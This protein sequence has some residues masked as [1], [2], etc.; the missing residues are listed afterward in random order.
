MRAGASARVLKPSLL[1]LLILALSG[2]LLWRAVARVPDGAFALAGPRV[3]Q[4]GLHVV[5]PWISIAVYPSSPVQ[6][7]STTERVTR[8]GARRTVSYTLRAAADPSRG[9]RLP[10]R[11]SQ[12]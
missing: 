4:P 9:D 7:A 2:S 1:L 5:V 6:V 11:R 3:L 8:E 10:P 12:G